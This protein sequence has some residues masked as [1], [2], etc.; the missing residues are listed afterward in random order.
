M[1][2]QAGCVNSASA[3]DDFLSRLEHHLLAACQM[4]SN[5][6]GN[7]V[8]HQDFGDVSLGQNSQIWSSLFASKDGVDVSNG[9]AASSAV[10]RV[11]GDVEEAGALG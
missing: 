1:K 4:K 9:C 3:E 8:F 2:H 7:I 6:A 10:I 11:V 5:A